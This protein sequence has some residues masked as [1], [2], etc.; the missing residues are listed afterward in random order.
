MIW[1]YLCVYEDWYSLMQSVAL[2][3]YACKTSNNDKLI[4]L[5]RYVCKWMMVVLHLATTLQC[6]QW[7]S[8]EI[9]SRQCSIHSHTTSQSMKIKFLVR[10]SFV[11]LPLMLTLAA[12]T[13]RWGMKQLARRLAML[14][15]TSLLAA[16]MASYMLDVHSAQ[17]TSYRNPS[18]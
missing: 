1:S 10:R 14:W 7:A 2:I 4:I 6:W 15:P 18:R 16:Q 13:M 3:A 17:I 12:L 5:S 11:C 9:C 8:Q